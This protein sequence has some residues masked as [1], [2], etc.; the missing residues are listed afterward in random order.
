VAFGVPARSRVYPSGGAFTTASVAMFV[1]APGRFSMMKVWPSRSDSHCPISRATM[2]FPGRGKADDKTH[3]PG[4]IGLRPRDPRHRGEGG[5]ARC[6]M[7]E[8]SSVGKFHGIASRNGGS[9]GSHSAVMS[10]ALTIGPV[11]DLGPLRSIRGGSRCAHVE[12]YFTRF[13]ATGAAGPPPEGVGWT[14]FNSSPVIARLIL[15]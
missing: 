5:S 13:H 1:A 14:Y 2:S 12:P 7:Q 15:F 9:A 10:A 3:R 6:Q 8:L 11:L 4:R